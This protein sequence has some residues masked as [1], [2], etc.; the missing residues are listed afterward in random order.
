MSDDEA[1]RLLAV[2][3][4]YQ[5]LIASQQ[6]L[7]L[8]TVNQHQQPEISYAPFVQD[9][10]GVFYIFVSE[11]ASHTANLLQSG[12][13]SIMI[14]RDEVQSR[15]LFARERVS[16]QCSASDIPLS[17]PVSEIPLTQLQERFGETIKL[18]RTLADFHLI[19]LTPETGRYVAGFGKAYDLILPDGIPVAVNG[20]SKK[21]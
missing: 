19:A 20:E 2:Q 5:A 7:I 15:N 10:Q 16:Y 3:N 17:D 1:D 14:V 18:L 11:L 12:R 4:A 21:K 8:S 9:E 6:T 13:T